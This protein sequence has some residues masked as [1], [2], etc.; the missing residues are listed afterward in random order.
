MFLGLRTV[1][2][3]DLKTSLA[4]LVYGEPLTIPG[5]APSTD[6]SDP[7]HLLGRLR[8]E[9]QQLRPIPTSRHGQ[10][11]DHVLDDIKSANYVFICHDGHKGPLQQP[12][13]GP[14]RVL[15]RGDKTFRI[16]VGGR[17]DTVTVGR[18]KRAHEDAAEPTVP[19]QPPRHGR[20]PN[21]VP[22]HSST[23]TDSCSSSSL[24]SSSH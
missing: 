11:P 14:F 2:K 6:T 24:A 10:Q 16:D 15:E 17:E 9:V 20:L 4:E 21:A 19:A 18:L 22:P 13:S 23:S 12:Y 7:A 8:E 3:E 5:D 1:V